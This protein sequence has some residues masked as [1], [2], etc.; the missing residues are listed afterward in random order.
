MLSRACIEGD[1]C[2]VGVPETCKTYTTINNKTTCTESIPATPDTCE[3]CKVK[4]DAC[5]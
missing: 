3:N 4:Y 1:E 2:T 5:P